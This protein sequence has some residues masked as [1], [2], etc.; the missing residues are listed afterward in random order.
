MEFNVTFTRYGFAVVEAESCSEAFEIAKGIAVEDITW[1]ED[2]EVSDAT[3]D[4]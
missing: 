2:F 4:E 3:E 1:S